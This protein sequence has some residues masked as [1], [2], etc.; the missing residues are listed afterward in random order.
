MVLPGTRYALYSNGDP[1]LPFAAAVMVVPTVLLLLARGPVIFHLPVE[2][3]ANYHRGC[4]GSLDA[5]KSLQHTMLAAGALPAMVF[6]ES[7]W[8]HRELV[9]GWGGRVVPAEHSLARRVSAAQRRRTQSSV[10]TTRS[11]CFR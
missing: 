2:W 5:Y 9:A 4:G 10:L 8:V 6:A 1:S 3:V 11:V 7:V